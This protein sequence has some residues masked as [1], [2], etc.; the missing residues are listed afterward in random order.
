MRTLL[1]SLSLKKIFLLFWPYPF[2]FFLMFIPLVCNA[3]T[4]SMFQKLSNKK[5]LHLAEKSEKEGN[6]ELAILCWEQ[7]LKRGY[8]NKENIIYKLAELYRK[9][10]NYL[11]AADYYHVLSS[12]NPSGYPDAIYYLA[13]MQKKRGFCDSAI[14]YFKKYK[15]FSGDKEYQN[16]KYEIEKETNACKL[17]DSLKNSGSEVVAFRLD[18]TINMSNTEFSPIIL[19]DTTIIYGSLANTK[20]ISQPVKKFYIAN[21]RNNYWT[22][23]I[24][25]K[26]DINSNH[27]PV[28]NGALSPDGE[29]LYFSRCLK[30]LTGKVKCSLYV[31]HFTGGNWTDS[32]S[33]PGVVNSG[34]FT[35]TQP[36]VAVDNKPTREV[37]YFVSD[38]PGGRGGLDIWFTVYDKVKEVYSEP[39]NAGNRINSSGNEATP[40]YH[41]PSHTMYFSSDGHPSLGGFDIFKSY[42]EKKNWTSLKNVGYPYNSTADDLYYVLNKSSQDGFFVSNRID[43]PGETTGQSCCDDI[44]YFKNRSLIKINVKGIIL[45]LEDHAYRREAGS[46]GTLTDTVED[47]LVSLYMV[48]SLSNETFFIESM[49]SGE[50]GQFEFRLEPGNRYKLTAAKEK[51]LTGSAKVSTKKIMASATLHSVIYITPV[52]EKPVVLD[53]IYY[54]FDRYELTDKS[55]SVLDS[56]LIKILNEN[57]L[58]TIEVLSHTD[59][60]GEDKYNLKL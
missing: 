34:N 16:V 55:K 49:N 19:N 43:I 17:R 56:V 30:D 6:N 52:P 14:F 1:G 39:K 42:G 8:A 51:Y 32:E 11:K 50:K 2:L 46:E 59:S 26:G 12:N 48:D 29:R 41:T 53:N 23:G 3:Q 44:F 38:R 54:E 24:E 4:D 7:C 22:G 45:A 15:K 25:M 33:L 9:S 58:I 18:S 47:A 27:L 20:G 13:L 36:A 35:I 10:D 21:Y 28:G 60:K 37:I 5:L 40:F 31:S 57:N